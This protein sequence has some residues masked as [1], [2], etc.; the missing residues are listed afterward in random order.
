M[1]APMETP[2]L[3]APTDHGRSGRRTP[4][5]PGC[6]SGRDESLV[7]VLGGGQKLK[8]NHHKPSLRLGK[9]VP[10]PSKM[11]HLLNVQWSVP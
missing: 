2:E 3:A 10:I 9:F 4:P 6:S 11:E 5:V 8:P 1:A 7:T